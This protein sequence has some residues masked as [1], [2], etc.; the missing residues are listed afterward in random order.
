MRKKTNRY[1]EK[2]WGRELTVVNA[3]EY[4]AKIIELQKGE[5]YNKKETRK[6]TI[7][8]WEGRLRIE[9]MGKIYE[10][11]KDEQVQIPA[12]V[13]SKFSALSKVRALFVTSE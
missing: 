5:N 9:A 6:L 12:D 13:R 1:I 11:V 3:K 10:L 7:H 4:S 8:V 2:S